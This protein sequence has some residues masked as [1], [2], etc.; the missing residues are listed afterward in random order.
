MLPS[1][2]P[3][4]SNCAFCA[5][6]SSS[7]MRGNAYTGHAAAKPVLRHLH[8]RNTLTELWRLQA[9]ASM[10]TGSSSAFLLSEAEPTPDQSAAMH[11]LAP[12]DSA[13]SLVHSGS[14]GGGGSPSKPMAT[15]WHTEASSDGA[16]FNH[17]A[18][19]LQP[20]GTLQVLPWS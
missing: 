18:A 2:V 19:V 9:A 10:T 4:S 16:Q 3:S 6:M 17:L 14:T 8:H 11:L 7:C 5:F 20:T 1:L 15:L 13:T 12:S